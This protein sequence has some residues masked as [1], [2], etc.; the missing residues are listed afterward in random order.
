MARITKPPEERRL[1]IIETAERLF[2]ELGY[3]N[4]PVETIIRE[5]GVAKGTF[6]HY[7]KS[8]QEILGAIVDRALG[9]ILEQA[10]AIAD[11]PSLTAMAKMEM[12]LADSHVGDDSTRDLA[13]MMHLPENRELHEITN[14]E[15]VLKLSP[16]FATIVKQGNSEGA[17]S[18]DR[19]L[20]TIQFLL[21]GAQ[22]LTD[23]GLF[24]FSE[25]EIRARR[26]ATQTI[27]ERSLGAEAGSFSFMNPGSELPDD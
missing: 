9:L 22:F 18:V 4:C 14:I 1:E 3:S 26:S 12:L 10:Q 23:G 5:I 17:F 21:T 16:V 15:T 2:K 7:F 24:R 25:G 13:E 6:Y 19:P 8:K 11:N 20:E 27:I